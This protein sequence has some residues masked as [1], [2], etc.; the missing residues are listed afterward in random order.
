MT[1]KI[2]S[3]FYKIVDTKALKE[4]A[5]LPNAQQGALVHAMKKGHTLTVE[6]VADPEGNR[7]HKNMPGNSGHFNGIAQGW[8]PEKL[9][10]EAVPTEDV[11]QDI[12]RYMSPL[13]AGLK[14][15]GD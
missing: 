5:F 4:G 14:P 13:T 7:M 3:G 11:P 15:I 6:T 10:L 9:G 2:K 1:D 12:K 8:T